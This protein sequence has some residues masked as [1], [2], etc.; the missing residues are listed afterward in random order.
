MRATFVIV[1][2][3]SVD[4]RDLSDGCTI[5]FSPSMGSDFFFSLSFDFFSMSCHGQKHLEGLIIFAF[6]TLLLVLSGWWKECFDGGPFNL[7]SLLAFIMTTVSE[8]LGVVGAQSFLLLLPSMKAIKGSSLFSS[9]FSWGK[10]IR[11]FF[12]LCH[13]AIQTICS[14]FP[15]K[16][17]G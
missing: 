2:I 8:S 7:L 15:E 16:S 4:V 14:D 9:R 5:L 3:Y 12:C 13:R 1:A 11:L 17:W 10:L 6:V